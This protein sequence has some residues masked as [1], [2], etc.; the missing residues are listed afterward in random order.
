MKSTAQPSKSKSDNPASGEKE[1]DLP[2]THVRTAPKA[3]I[4]RHVPRAHV[5][6]EK[7]VDVPSS[8]VNH[9]TLYLQEIAKTPLLKPHEEVALA[10]RI[11][12]GD[13]E[14]RNHMI[15]ANLRL[16]VKIA[17]DYSHIGI[18]LMD[19]ISEGNL[20][21]V[22]AVERFDP[23]KGG[24]LS[25]YASWWIK[26]AI[27]RTFAYQGRP[28]KLPVHMI[29]KIAR[30]RRV[31]AELTEEFSREPSN[32]EISIEM[33]MPINKVAHLRAISIRPAS[34]DAPVGEDKDS[35]LSDLIGDESSLSPFESL[36]NESLLKDLN[37]VMNELDPRESQIIRMRFGIGGQTPMTL[38]EIGEKMQVTRERIRQLQNLA[39]HQ[40]RRKLDERDSQKMA[41]EDIEKAR[42]RQ[43]MQIIDEFL[44]RRELKSGDA[45]AKGD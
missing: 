18:P 10:A 26:Q 44:K 8:E 41:T 33:D 19:L 17:R 27:K 25:T 45:E 42:K 2:K 7:E 15:Q 9:L 29:D 31:I 38:E 13:K 1:H 28:I 3:A 36:R 6:D 14:A 12:A 35:N 40:L 23:A 4:E 43:S 11:Q 20:G 37:T 30:M 32:E 39:L 22:K 21:L 5:E 24:K 34:L 16:V